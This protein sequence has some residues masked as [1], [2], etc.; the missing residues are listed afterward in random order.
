MAMAFS[1]HHPGAAAA[2]GNSSKE[3]PMPPSFTISMQAVRMRLLSTH[4]PV[5]ST[6]GMPVAS[7]ISCRPR[8]AYRKAPPGRPGPPPGPPGDDPVVQ[9]APAAA[10]AP[11]QNVGDGLR[12]EAG[13]HVHLVVGDGDA[14]RVAAG[15]GGA[16]GGGDLAGHPPGA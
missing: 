9:R 3:R 4:D 15:G 16:R 13:D 2:T 12:G 14:P 10:I 8:P 6:G 5:C 1:D 7:Q 11:A